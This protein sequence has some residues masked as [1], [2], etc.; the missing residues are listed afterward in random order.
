LVFETHG[1]IGRYKNIYCPD[2]G[3]NIATKSYTTPLK[4]PKRRG[5]SQKEIDLVDRCLSGELQVYAVAHK[6]GRTSKSI[7][8]QMQ[9]RKKN[10]TRLIEGAWTFKE[11]GI[12]RDYL[13]EY[14]PRP[15]FYKDLSEKLGRTKNQVSC[16]IYHMRK[17][18]MLGAE[19]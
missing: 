16:K 3:E 12:I 13:D 6:I 1:K 17:K 11:E 4:D 19:V 10:E 14:G 5:W 7:S 15:V 2:C 18:G 9:R 8:R